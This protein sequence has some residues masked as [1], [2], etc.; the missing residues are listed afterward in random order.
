MSA[1]KKQPTPTGEM[2]EK[3]RRAWVRSATGLA[4]GV[5]LVSATGA[6]A[7]ASI[8][9]NVD[10]ATESFP[11]PAA[12]VPAGEYSAVC[13]EPLR[14]LEGTIDGGDPEFSPV[15]RTAANRV[16]AMVL[17]DLGGVVPGSA[18]VPLAGGDPLAVL[19]DAV[20]ESEQAGP[21]VSN[22]EGLTN[23]VAAVSADQTVDAASVLGAQAVGD[24]RATAGAAFSYTATDGDLAGLAVAG[25]QVPSNDFWLV[26]AVTT[27]GAAAVLNLHNP[28]ESPATVN[29]DL[30]GAKGAIEAPAGRDILIAPG[31]SKPVVVAA[32]AANEENVAI[33]VR[34]DGGRV[35]GF[36]Q[37]S[38]LRG[39][40]PGGVE[41][42]QASA[43]SASTQVVPG[44]PIQ[45]PDVMEEL[46]SQE[47][48][49]GAAPSLQVAVP[50]GT[51]AVLDVRVF[52]PNGEVELPGGGVVTAAAGAVTAIPLDS[53]PEGNYSAVVSSDV[54]VSASARAARGSEPE[55]PLD[56]AHIASA[57]R[58]GSQHVS[59]LPSGAGA[60]FVFSAPTGRA[61][62]RLTPVNADG[63]LGEERVYDVAGGTTVTVPAADLG[64]GTAAALIGVSGDPV[65]GSQLATL[66]GGPGIS[67]APIPPG[68]AGQQ[69]VPVNLGY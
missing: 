22:E 30:Y 37:Q 58:L 57:A 31:A 52:G 19:A 39:L 49:A 32:L 43:P 26:G 34:S 24:Q 55:E 33:R 4:T 60:A 23:R 61:E 9:Q 7:G 64:K 44:I 29:L 38:V 15:S 54:L 25:C 48:Y 1:T 53:L 6:L 16:S 2:P 13:P 20:P 69:T 51:D 27:V 5:V 66:S 40:T 67:V 62:V 11:V 47:G 59:V 56:F 46:V 41:L 63:V 3:G 36:I 17:S 65:Y 18:L 42:I 50:G 8:V 21:Q 45:D 12:A 68:G 10:G 14:L 35:S 28:T